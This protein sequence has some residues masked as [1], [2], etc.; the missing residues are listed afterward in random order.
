MDISIQEAKRA[1]ASNRNIRLIDVRTPEEYRQGCIAG[2]V[3]VPL[4]GI[5][6]YNGDKNAQIFVYCQS[7]GR[8]SKAKQALIAAGYTKVTNIGGISGWALTRPY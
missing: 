8:S 1:L 4:A 6:S 3:N 7:G 5:S 2:S